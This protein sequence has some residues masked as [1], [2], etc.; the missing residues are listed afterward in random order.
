MSLVI[1]STT[2]PKVKDIVQLLTKSKE[3]KS[4]GL[5]IVEG[6]REINRAL[7]SNWVPK[8]LW[9]L[10]GSDVPLQS[11]S[12]PNY[13]IATPKV[14]QK[15]AYRNTTECAVAV[16]AIP[17][18][19]MNEYQELLE[20]AKCLLVLEGIEKPGNLGACLRSACAAGVDA[21][22][23]ADSAVDPYSPNVIRNSTGALFEIPLITA[24]SEE[25][26]R[27]FNGNGRKVYVTNLHEDAHSMFNIK[28][29][30]KC[31]L[32]LGEEASGLSETWVTNDYENI[33]IPMEG[34]TIDSLNVSVS[35]A[36]LM[37]QW[38]SQQ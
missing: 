6:A 9:Q 17:A 25:L 32:V 19:G 26:I 30:N 12:F 16:F 24:S 7:A 1:S 23:L 14:F 2:N 4:R 28:W 34:E 22:I 15:L 38:R 36:L 20:S 11:A 21:V 5:C 10:E 13:Y 27:L 37:Y 35:A 18:S 33:I 8:E 29:P 3:R 31:A